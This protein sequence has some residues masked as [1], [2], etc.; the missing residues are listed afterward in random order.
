MN[1]WLDKDE[2]DVILD[3][4]K[5]LIYECNRTERIWM[6][7]IVKD[8]V[9]IHSSYPPKV[10]YSAIERTTCGLY[11][12][13][14]KKVPIQGRLKFVSEYV[15]GYKSEIVESPTWLQIA[16]LANDMMHISDDLN[17][18]FLEGIY[19]PSMAS[20]GTL[21]WPKRPNQVPQQV[22]QDQVLIVQFIM[23]S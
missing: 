6:E 7:Q 3:K 20:D 14:L 10:V 18:Q 12:D 9:S 22:P 19:V 2:L 11:K 13:N 15:R 21:C 1:H 16:S 4:N 17:H 23:G 5:H 8:Y